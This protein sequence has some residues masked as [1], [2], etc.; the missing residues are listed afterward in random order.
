MS[1]KDE[2]FQA[3]SREAQTVSQ[4]TKRFDVTRNA[5]VVHLRQLESA[6][7]VT[8]SSA[9]RAGKVGK[10]A[11]VYVAKAGTEDRNSLAYRALAVMLARSVRD[12]LDDGDRDRFYRQMGRREGAAEEV[13]RLDGLEARLKAV[14]AF[15]DGLGAATSLEWTETRVILR[16]YTCPIGSVVRVEPC[17]CKA[18]AAMFE[19]MTGHPTT[20]TC[21]RGAKLV[22]QF[23]FERR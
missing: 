11:A 15:A 20:E 23:E 16:S 12:W 19:E 5:V 4:L 3:L 6:G 13:S 17:A 10:P 8:R 7:L 21:R 2:L 14:Q 9:P 18:L 22:C 1:L